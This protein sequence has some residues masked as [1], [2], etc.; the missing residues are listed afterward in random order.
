MEPLL[1]LI[2]ALAPG[3]QLN[4][5]DAGIYVQ[6][7]DGWEVC[8]SEYKLSLLPQKLCKKICLCTSSFVSVKLLAVQDTSTHMKKSSP[9][10][11]SLLVTSHAY[12][13][14]IAGLLF[15]NLQFHFL[16]FMVTGSM[17]VCKANY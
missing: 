6:F 12:R 5:R 15:P 13:R 14:A 2:L 11:T 7:R 1:V 9:D 8:N 3:L 10:S 16:L 4:L 17:L